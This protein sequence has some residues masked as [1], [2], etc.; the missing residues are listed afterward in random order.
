MLT[1][2]AVLLAGGTVALIWGV[3]VPW[4]P[5]ICP[6]IDPAPRNCRPDHRSGTATITTAIVGVIFVVTVFCG[7]V[8]PRRQAYLSGGVV[9]LALAPFVSYPLI[10]FL[11]GFPIG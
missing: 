9:L 4:G 3:A 2:S 6:A 10:A 11:P 5:V 1:L 7:W 8:F